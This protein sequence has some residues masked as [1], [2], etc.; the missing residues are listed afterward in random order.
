MNHPEAITLPTADAPPAD[1]PPAAEPAALTAM[2][3]A[4]DPCVTAGD[5]HASGFSIQAWLERTAWRSLKGTVNGASGEMPHPVFWDDPLMQEIYKLDVATFLTAEQI[6][7]EGIS[8]LVAMAP[9]E[10]SRLFLATQTL[11]E[12]RH[13]EV[14]C[15]RLADIGVSPAQRQALVGRV[16]TSELR[17]F[18]DLIREQVDRGDV[19][20]A[21]A[22]HNIIL[23]G[24][25]YPVYRYEIR[26]WSRLDPGLSHIVQGAFA[27][28]V[29]HVGFGE[30]FIVDAVRASP[31]TRARVTALCRD[32]ARLMTAVFESVI[33]KYIGLYQTV[34]DRHMAL[35]G[36][37]LLFPGHRMADLSEETQVR[38]LLAEVQ[39][40]LAKRLAAIDI[41]ID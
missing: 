36:D 19:V 3:G 2:P 23:E 39:R 15:R 37:V 35:M 9:D 38:M 41:R 29:R 10:A 8:R 33:H 5:W 27:D 21:L 32:A 28:E 34:A 30:A 24:M 6:S 16:V 12:A 31:P 18:Y 22:A 40:E 26:Y 11:D 13:F 25:A 7:V 1:A 14:F 17:T 4:A 20:C